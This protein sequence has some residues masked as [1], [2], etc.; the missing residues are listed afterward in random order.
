MPLSDFQSKL[1]IIRK[2]LMDIGLRNNPLLHFRGGSKSLEVVS[3][4]SQ[5]LFQRICLQNRRL[6]FSPSLETTSEL[7]SEP[8]ESVFRSLGDELEEDGSTEDEAKGNR[9]GQRLRTKL[10]SDRLF[11]TLLKIHA[12]ATTYLEEQGV[13]ILFLALGFL[14]WFESDSSEELRRAPLFLAP[15]RLV[16]GT[17]GNDFK[18]ISTGEEPVVNPALALKLKADFGLQLPDYGD[19]P[20]DTAQLAAY[21]EKCSACIGA[22]SR[23]RVVQDE[24]HLGFFS[25]GK[26]LMYQDLAPEAWG[27]DQQLCENSLLHRLLGEESLGD[28]PCV[29]EA[30]HLDKLIEPGDVKF[31]MDADSSQTIA[32]L[33]A[34]EGR[35]LVIEGPPGT[36]KSQ[37]IANI[38]AE[39]IDKGKTV[40]FV[41]EKMAALEVVQ[42]RLERCQLG[43][44]VL[45]LHSHKS[46]KQ[47]VLKEL[48]RTVNQ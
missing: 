47:S 14:H 30:E 3:S 4:E 43:D 7:P 41:S 21:F 18:L 35:N 24:I 44:A 36:G 27:E 26:F 29:G 39:L 45:E 2:E 42:K 13:N 48:E 16:R 40:L 5:D 12:D 31:V 37:T 25:F 15:A 33:E 38:I 20:E 11:L 46:T 19:D 28:S 23:W 10:P 34:R 8:D 32:I 22:Q 1:L 9:S 6:S 17:R